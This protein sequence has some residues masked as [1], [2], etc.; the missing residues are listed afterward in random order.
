ME[1]REITQ[2]KLYEL[3]LNGI[4]DKAELRQFVA[5]SPCLK[6]IQEF[7]LENVTTPYQEVYPHFNLGI[8]DYTWK[9][10]FLKN[11][12]LE[13]FNPLYNLAMLDPHERNF[14][15]YPLGLGVLSSWVPQEHW[16]QFKSQLI[17]PDFPKVIEPRQVF[18]YV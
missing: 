12:P 1:T 4:E 16:D 3:H 18:N 17:M 15:L 7:Y 13:F 11:G 14:Y 8:T 10:Y 6:S 9:K 2:I 5:V